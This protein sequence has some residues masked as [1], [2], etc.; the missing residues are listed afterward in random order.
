MN[1]GQDEPD[2]L[3]QETPATGTSVGPEQL[4]EQKASNLP[5]NIDMSISWTA[6]EFI[7]HEK[8]A[9]WYIYL[10][11]GAIV[12]AGIIY[13]LT[14][15]AITASTIIIA[16]IAL[17]IFAAKKPREQQY[18]IDR[19]GL[20]VGDHL[21]PFEKFRSFAVMRQ[22]EF[23]SL[24]FMPM[25]RFAVGASVYFNPADETKIVDLLSSYLPMQ[26]KGQDPLDG[27]MWRI[28]F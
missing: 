10:F 28:R 19:H 24:Q 6:S 7:A 15:D 4:D 1:N 23:S 27:F 26:E 16:A 9:S 12:L 8:G 17:A 18:R 14:K 2:V 25:R 3:G 5:G 22:G 11:I 20:S 21:Y 13:V